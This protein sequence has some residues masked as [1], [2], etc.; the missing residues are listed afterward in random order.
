MK[1]IGQVEK[2][3]ML[4]S[5]KHECL[6]VVREIYELSHRIRPKREREREVGVFVTMIK[7]EENKRD[8]R[9]IDMIS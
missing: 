2:K 9:K 7:G 8:K 1:M 3:P 5:Q 4:R 6:V